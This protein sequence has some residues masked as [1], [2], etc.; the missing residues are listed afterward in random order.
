MDSHDVW[1]ICAFCIIHSSNISISIKVD[2]IKQC[3]SRSTGIQA[4]CDQ[5]GNFGEIN[6]VLKAWFELLLR[7]FHIIEGEGRE[8]MGK[9]INCLEERT[10][11]IICC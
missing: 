10:S 7:G 9:Y 2:I 8:I 1:A 11:D 5:I 6:D 3:I 4:F